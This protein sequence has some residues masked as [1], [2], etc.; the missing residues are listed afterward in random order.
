MKAVTVVDTHT[1]LLKVLLDQFPARGLHQLILGTAK[2][3]S[4]R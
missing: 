4:A 3:R 1:C 2:T